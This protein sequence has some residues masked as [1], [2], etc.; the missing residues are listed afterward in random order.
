MLRSGPQ[1]PSVEV[2]PSKNVEV[3]IGI[4]SWVD[5]NY[6]YDYF[7]SG[8]STE[9]LKTYNASDIISRSQIETL[10]YYKSEDPVLS[11]KV[12]DKIYTN[13]DFALSNKYR[14]LVLL[15]CVSIDQMIS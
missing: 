10:R 5:P 6:G 9:G 2:A 13:R 15:I 4:P 12:D 3:Q 1:P 14:F 11:L 8:D 7:D